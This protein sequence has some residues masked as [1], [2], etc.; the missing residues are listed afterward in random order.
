MPKRV[1]IPTGEVFG[2]LTVIEDSGLVHKTK[3]MWRCRCECGSVCLATAGN[4]F[5]SRRT[6]CM[7][8]CG[9]YRRSH[10][11]SLRRT[12][13]LL[14]HGQAR[15][16]QC[17]RTWNSWSSMLQRCLTQSTPGWE[18]YGGRGITVCKRWQGDGGFARFYEDMGERPANRSLD[19]IDVNG[20]YEPGNCRW[21]TPKEQVANRRPFGSAAQELR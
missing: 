19:R 11:Q 17:S 12:A 14:E 7:I 18:Y 6:G 9:C 3:R 4:L 20:N 13:H 8:S 16:G 1:P 21:A 5:K 2:R 15:R 10:E